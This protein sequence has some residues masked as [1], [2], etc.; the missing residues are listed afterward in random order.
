MVR[1]HTA[2]N[3]RPSLEVEQLN[4]ARAQLANIYRLIH[5]R[6]LGGVEQ[7]DTWAGGG[8]LPTATAFG[9]II[10]FLS[11]VYDS[12]KGV[13]GVDVGASATSMAAAFIGDL[14]LEVTS[15]RSWQ[16]PV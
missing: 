2:P 10:S 15:S 7:L 13:L 9:R 3:V 5:S 4:T 12:A 6:K 8:L 1:L 14:I 11:K 16:Q